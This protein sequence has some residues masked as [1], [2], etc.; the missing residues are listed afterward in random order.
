MAVM[1]L[2]VTGLQAQ[3]EAPAQA[4]PPDTVAAPV[5]VD[6]GNISRQAQADGD[7]L[8]AIAAQADLAEAIA[9]FDSVIGIRETTMDSL[10]QETSIQLESRRSTGRLETRRGQWNRIGSGWDGTRS[11]LDAL[12]SDLQIGLDT[13]AAVRERW[14]TTRDSTNAVELPEAL[15]DRIAQMLSQVDSTESLLRRELNT[16]LTLEDR[17]TRLQGRSSQVLKEIDTALGAARIR[18]IARDSRP[19]WALLVERPA[20]TPLFEQGKSLFSELWEGAQAALSEDVDPLIWHVVLTLAFLVWF[21]YESFR[22]RAWSQDDEGLKVAR[23][24]LRRPVSAVIVLS[25][26]LLRVTYPAAPVQFINLL[27]LVVVVPLFWMLPPLVPRTMRPAL[28]AFGG[29]FLFAIF[30]EL[31]EPYSV[32]WRLALLV[33]NTMGGLT[34]VLALR[35]SPKLIDQP[36]AWRRAFRRLG[37]GIGVVL[38]LAVP[39]NVFGFTALSHVLV[40]GTYLAIYYILL[41]LAATLI[42]E[43][44]WVAFLRTPLALKSNAVKHNVRL[45]QRRGTKALRLGAAVVWVGMLLQVFGVYVP[46]TTWLVESLGHVWSFG[47]ISLSLGGILAFVVTLWAA[48]LLSRFIRFLLEEDVMARVELPRGVPRAVTILVHYVLLTVAFLL[49]VSA[50]GLDLAK[51]TILAGAFGLAIGFGMQNIINNFVSGLI[52]LFERPIQIGDTVEVGTLLGTVRRIGIRSS[53]IRT[54]AGSEVI[55]PNANLISAEV[56]N[57]TLSDP[58][59]RVSVKVGTAY[60]TDPERVLAILTEVAAAHPKV[61]SDPKPWPLF[62]GFGDSSLD[63]EVRFWVEQFDDGMQ[64]GSDVTVAVNT[65]LAE[66]GIEIPFPQRDL[67]VRSVSP[68]AQQVLPNPDP[69]PRQEAP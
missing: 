35:A 23:L 24:V 55:V 66:A 63:F 61:S 17:V 32:W 16:I 18:L 49:A 50:A 5:V 58:R 40:R 65:A 14:Q 28:Y 60:G 36:S 13:V 10:E 41:V 8:A 21:T 64:V 39:A 12:A 9:R 31:L 20:D 34:L 47:E 25:V 22:S 38:T 45:L 43:A 7:L 33:G 44:T 19:L 53:T 54:Y 59:R 52:L 29:V 1:M 3:E 26:L 56:V 2:S 27:T 62:L 46:V 67:H 30:V 57:W 15:N 6:Q 48:V 68:E 69:R 37:Y 4:A 11:R 42:L 51:L